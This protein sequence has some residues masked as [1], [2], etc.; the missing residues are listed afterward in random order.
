M[1]LLDSS[2]TQLVASEQ[3]HGRKVHIVRKEDMGRGS[4]TL[5]TAIPGVDGLMTNVPGIMLSSYYADCVPLFFLDPIKKVIALAHAGWK[6]TLQKIADITLNRMK[7]EFSSDPASCL[8]A[9]G[10]AI[11]PCCFRVDRAVLEKFVQS[12]DDLDHFCFPEDEE[13]WFI[14][15]PGLNEQQLIRSGI[16]E[17]HIT[18]SR[19]CTG[20]NNNTFFSYRKQNGQTGR[21]ASFIMLKEGEQ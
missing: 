13:K 3:V 10:P 20:C 6:G 15:L 2:L 4:I 12:F 18:R 16:L 7:Q 5:D 9:I 17:E 14:D 19:L 8:A 1:N 11:G 21:Q